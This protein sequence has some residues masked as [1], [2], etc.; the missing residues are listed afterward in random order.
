M[1]VDDA[2]AGSSWNPWSFIPPQFNLGAALTRGQVEARP[3]RQAGDP[4]GKRSPRDAG[5]SLIRNW[6]R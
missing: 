5:R 2:Q 1:S 6:T 3:R 4:L